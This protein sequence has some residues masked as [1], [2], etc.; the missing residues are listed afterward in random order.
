MKISLDDDND[1]TWLTEAKTELASGKLNYRI[2][3]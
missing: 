3:F 1:E 2:Y